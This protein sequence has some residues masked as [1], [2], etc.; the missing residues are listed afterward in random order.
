MSRITLKV[1]AGVPRLIS[2]KSVAGLDTR[3]KEVP[4]EQHTL[5]IHV[6]FDGNRVVTSRADRLLLALRRRVPVSGVLLLEILDLVL[7]GESLLF[8]C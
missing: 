1:W 5:S 4:V 7:H 8:D 2:E 3:G 6:V